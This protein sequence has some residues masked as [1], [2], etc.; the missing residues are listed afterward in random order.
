MASEGGWR[1]GIFRSSYTGIS[2]FF[3]CLKGFYSG[4]FRVKSSLKSD[5]VLLFIK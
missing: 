3:S 5:F 4:T 2:T 1:L